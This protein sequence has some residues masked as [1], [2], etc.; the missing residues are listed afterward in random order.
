MKKENLLCYSTRDLNTF[1]L[2]DY[3]NSGEVPHIKIL[4]SAQFLHDRAFCVKSIMLT[5]LGI[6]AFHINFIN[7]STTVVHACVTPCNF[8]SFYTKLTLWFLAGGLTPVHDLHIS[9]ADNET[10]I[11]KNGGY[12]WC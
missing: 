12:Q 9:V 3:L 1:I 2:Q 11:F 7:A 4:I 10:E 5:V 6:E 8:G